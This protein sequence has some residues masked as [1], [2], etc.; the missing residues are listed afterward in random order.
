MCTVRNLNIDRSSD[1]KTAK[2]VTNRRKKL[3]DK[4]YCFNFT[5]AKNRAA[6]CRSS[7]NCFKHKKKHHLFICDKLDDSKPEPC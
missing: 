4:N 3:S 2:T 5:G 6:E 7:K 1:F